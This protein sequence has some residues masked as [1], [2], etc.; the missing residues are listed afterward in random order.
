MTTRDTMGNTVDVDVVD[1]NLSTPCGGYPGN[2]TSRIFSVESPT[3]T[4]EIANIEIAFTG[5]ACVGDGS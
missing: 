4:A 1:S 3:G 2:A 5:P